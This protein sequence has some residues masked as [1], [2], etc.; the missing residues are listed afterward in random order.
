MKRK[1]WAN[2]SMINVINSVEGGKDLREAFQLCNIFME[3]LRRRVTG[4]VD[5]VCI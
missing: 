4:T 1:M 5:I 3:T 2:E